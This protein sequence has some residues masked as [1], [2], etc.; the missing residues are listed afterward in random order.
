[1]QHYRG[2]GVE[3]KQG[4]KTMMA[5]AR[6][7]S[8]EAA[9][10][11]H[12]LYNYTLSRPASSMLTNLHDDWPVSCRVHTSAAPG[13]CPPHLHTEHPATSGVPAHPE[14]GA[15]KSCAYFCRTSCLPP[16]PPHPTP[17]HRRRAYPPASSRAHTY[18]APRTCPP[19]SG[20]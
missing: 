19:G 13:T 1:M 4:C 9:T 10:H 17:N 2:R 8:V 15:Q 3:R 5:G 14:V 20:L 6:F 18:A 7:G 16:T 11:P 12:V